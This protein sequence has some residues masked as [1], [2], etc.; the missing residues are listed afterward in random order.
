MIG[1]P[2][3]PGGAPRPS[4]TRSVSAAARASRAAATPAGAE[5][6]PSACRP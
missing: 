3:E 6:V 4:R 2:T 1:A 5:R